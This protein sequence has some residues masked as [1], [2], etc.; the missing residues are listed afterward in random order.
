[1][2]QVAAFGGKQ[3]P[4]P[5]AAVV[6]APKNAAP[7][8]PSVPAVT[9]I[10]GQRQPEPETSGPAQSASSD[11]PSPSP[12]APAEQSGPT[13]VLG[14]ARAPSAP[15]AASLQAIELPLSPLPDEEILV[16]EERA[17]GVVALGL[18]APPS[19]PASCSRGAWI[20]ALPVSWPSF[21]LTLRILILQEEWLLS[22][23]RPG[24]PLGLPV[25]SLRRRAA[26]RIRPQALSAGSTRGKPAVANGWLGERSSQQPRA[27]A[28]RAQRGTLRRGQCS[29]L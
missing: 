5:P 26:R 18:G 20:C 10:P 22:L 15:T 9:L 28:R 16:E 7:A 4:P 11:Q 1:M 24:V 12:V 19:P 23:L 21:D 14:P 25:L 17:Y 8:G 13:S 2:E 29:R 27:A 3:T 6:N